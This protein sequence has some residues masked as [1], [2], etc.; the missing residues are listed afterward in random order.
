[1]L[2]I[3]TEQLL[4]MAQAT[5]RLP[6]RSSGKPVQVAGLYRW[7]S[8]GLQD[9]KLEILQLGGHKYTSVEALERF[10]SKLTVAMEAE[11]GSTSEVEALEV[12]EHE[13]RQALGM[14]SQASKGQ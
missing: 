7:A 9:I 12:E 14:T 6:R 4:S 13:A 5:R 2:D 1:M 3:K 11:E 10:F 8:E